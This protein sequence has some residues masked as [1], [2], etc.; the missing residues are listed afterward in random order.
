MQFENAAVVHESPS[1]LGDP[2]PIADPPGEPDLA[3]YILNKAGALPHDVFDEDFFADWRAWDGDVGT[4][5]L[6]DPSGLSHLEVAD[7]ITAEPP[8]DGTPWTDSDLDGIDDGWEMA[9]TSG[10]YAIDMVTP[11]NREDCDLDGFTD[12]EEYL[13]ILAANLE[14]FYADEFEDGSD[15]I[16]PPEWTEEQG[17]WFEEGGELVGERLT[18]DKARAIAT[19]IEACASECRFEATLRATNTTGGAGDDVHVKLL[20][21]YVGVADNVSL[22]LEIFENKVKGE[23][24]KNGTTTTSFFVPF[25]DPNAT[26]QPDTDYDVM[27]EFNPATNRYR[28]WV[29][30][31]GTRPDR[32]GGISGPP[33]SGRVG[34]QSR[35]ADALVG[36]V[37][38][39]RNFDTPILEEGAGQ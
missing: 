39:G 29:N 21:W 2:P 20:G 25:A 37:A 38:V 8:E 24:K 12:L 34:V 3:S 22:T 31:A 19:G 11:D 23:Q 36:R 26:L 33:T 17:N 13:D 7:K 16:P 9:D 35:N 5:T 10:C 14:D 18:D 4:T 6:D 27:I 15:Q 1:E 28:F 32:L 30:P